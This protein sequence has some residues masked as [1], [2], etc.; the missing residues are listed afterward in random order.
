VLPELLTRAELAK[1]LKISE[2]T[3]DA[4]RAEGMPELKAGD[5]PR[6]EEAA[7]R[8]WMRGRP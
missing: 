1:T 3:L 8:E 2:R 7:V 4:M 5:S 6:F